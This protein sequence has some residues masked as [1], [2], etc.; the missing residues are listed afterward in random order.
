MN[1]NHFTLFTDFVDHYWKRHSEHQLSLFPDV[2]GFGWEWCK[3]LGLGQQFPRRLLTLSLGER[4]QLGMSTRLPTCGLYNMVSW[5]SLF[6]TGVCRAL[7]ESI[8]S[9]QVHGFWW[10]SLRKSYSITSTGLCG[11]PKFKGVD[12]QTLPWLGRSI[13]EFRIMLKTDT[14]CHQSSHLKVHSLT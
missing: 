3:L 2:W 8:S 6:L 13:K 5:D 4:T 7:G 10:P 9:D 1:N 12:V 11:P 14:F